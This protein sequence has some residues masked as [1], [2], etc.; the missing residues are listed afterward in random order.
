M[1]LKP[2]KKIKLT[3][4]KFFLRINIKNIFRGGQII[5]SYL[6]NI[7]RSTSFFTFYLTILRAVLCINTNLRG[8]KFDC[9]NK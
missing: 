3:F 7:L 9:I 4:K 6:M 5:L 8:G 1:I 2:S